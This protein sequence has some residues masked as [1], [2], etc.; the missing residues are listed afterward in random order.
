MRELTTQ[1][2]NLFG[3]VRPDLVQGEAA[4]SRVLGDVP[5]VVEMLIG[6]KAVRQIQM[7]HVLGMLHEEA[8]KGPFNF[9]NLDIP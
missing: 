5:N 9:P 3:E 6:P 1:L 2:P 4:E 7:M 8:E